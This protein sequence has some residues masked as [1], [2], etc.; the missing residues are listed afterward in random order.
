MELTELIADYL[1][2]EDFFSLRL[3][4]RMLHDKTSDLFAKRYFTR[5]VVKLQLYSLRNLVNISKHPTLAKRVKVLEITPT[6][7]D[8]FDRSLMKRLVH[9]WAGWSSKHFKGH[10]KK[11]NMH[12]YESLQKIRSRFSKIIDR[13]LSVR[14]SGLVTAVLTQAFMGFESLE[15]LRYGLF[16]TESRYWDDQMADYWNDAG[17][18]QSTGV[19]LADYDWGRRGPNWRYHGH[20]YLAHVL[21]AMMVSRI[22]VSRLNLEAGAYHALEIPSLDAPKALVLQDCFSRLKCLQFSLSTEYY[23]TAGVE[24]IA[25]LFRNM[26]QSIE[27][28]ELFTQNAE[29]GEERGTWQL[30]AA[31]AIWCVVLEE[32]NFPRLHSLNL[33]L[34]C[35]SLAP[36]LYQFIGGHCNSLRTI[37]VSPCGAARWDNQMNKVKWSAFLDLFLSAPNLDEIFFQTPCS[38]YDGLDNDTCHENLGLQAGRAS[39]QGKMKIWKQAEDDL[40]LS[41][42]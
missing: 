22:K 37:R 38:I 16:E 19:A 32:S 5:R 17:L 27:E 8:T 25:S 21:S 28:L 7:Q 35:A 30:E 13:N 12:I 31:K 4:N 10:T 18:Q 3:T 24:D 23:K 11:E 14:P 33:A 40:G 6:I 9:G 42:D 2:T 15:S 36:C 41:S 29:H 20:C 1:S 34:A 39:V 26:P